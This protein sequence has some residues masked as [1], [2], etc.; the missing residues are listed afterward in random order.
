[1]GA[2]D[3]GHLRFGDFGELGVLMP[4]KR[5]PFTARMD[6]VVKSDGTATVTMGP[7]SYLENWETSIVGVRNTPKPPATS[8]DNIPRAEIWLG[9]VGGIFLGGTET[10]D[11]DSD[12]SMVVPVQS[13]NVLVGYWT[14]ADVGSTVT[15]SVSGWKDVPD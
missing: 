14:G 1:M 9:S 13:Q 2:A 6:G 11:F 3:G 7:S 10:G 4:T 15:L 5:V 8:L 12:T